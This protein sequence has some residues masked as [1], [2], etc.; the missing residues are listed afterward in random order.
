MEL[1]RAASTMELLGRGMVLVFEIRLD[2]C[3]TK[4][5]SCLSWTN[6]DPTHSKHSIDDQPSTGL[7]Y[8]GKPTCLGRH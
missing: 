2:V 7:R 8:F 5:S 6:T 1:R 3:W 4:G